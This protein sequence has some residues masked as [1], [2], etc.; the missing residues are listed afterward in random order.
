MLRQRLRWH[1]AGVVRRH[2]HEPLGQRC[3][4][5]QH[6]VHILVSHDADQKDEFLPG[7]AVFQAL[8]RGA[9][10]VGVVAAV[11]HKG[12]AV[13][14]QFKAPG[15]TYLLQ[16][17][18]DGTFRD[19][20]A[21]LPQHPQ[22]GDGQRGV[23]G[24][25]AAD[26][27]QPHPVQPVK[28]EGN[29]VQIPAGD[30]Q[31]CKVHLRKGSVL[32]CRHPAQHGVCL[33][34]AAVAHHRAAW[35]DDARLG[36]GD[37]RQRRAQLLDVIHAQCRDHR[38]GRLFDD[39]GGIQRAAK[40]HFQHHD[41]ALLLRKIEHAQ[42]GDDLKLGGH[43]LHGVG[44]GLYLFHQRHQRL[45]RDLLPVD[46][47]ALVEPV[48][49]DLKAFALAVPGKVAE[50]MDK[51]RVADAMT[52][53]FTL[54]KRLNKYIDETMPWALAKDE[55]KKDRLATVLYNLVEGITMGATLLESF[56]PETTERILAQLNAQKRT[57]EDL[58]TFGLYP[59]GNKV[60]EKPEILFAR[61]DL[62]EV[63]AK[64]EE[65]HPKKEEPVEEK[66]E[67]NVIDIEAKPEITFDDFGKLQFQVGEIIACEEVKKSRK[68]LCSQ[69]KI[70]SQVRQIVSGIKAHYSAEE[71][72]GKKVMVVT[73]LKPAKLA[74]IL[75]EGMILC[76]E[77]AD[78]KLSLM[79]P[80]KEMPAGAEIC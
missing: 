67:E 17:G 25:I 21:L 48:D 19:V 28:A 2:G 27:R 71:M 39:V 51:L 20:P 76:A 32:L 34:C 72:V 8:H 31:L 38:A 33:R 41:I 13:A 40:P 14:Q 68:L 46:L 36:S 11:Q 54:F 75:S 74:G 63:L 3:Q 15:P 80:E 5:R 56:M 60:T 73:N 50:K 57:L 58:K 12:R 47:D 69:V 1:G 44:G 42:C 59:S 52:E 18:A 66:K 4:Q 24:L 9:H 53:V 77:D 43:V 70:G 79:V 7:E 10:P 29:C 55:A 62:K 78:G 37:I 22:G 35:L 30:L 49:E 6:L 45:V 26:E 23:A 64:V 65:L 61:L 16:P